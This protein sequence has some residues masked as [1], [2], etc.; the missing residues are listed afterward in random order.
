MGVTAGEQERA[1][2]EIIYCVEC[3]LRPA[4]TRLATAIRDEFGLAA[5]LEEGHGGIF[6]VRINDAVVFNNF[7]RGGRL[8]TDQQIFQEIREHADA[9]TPAQG[10][11]IV[12]LNPRGYPPAIERV[13]LAPRPNTLDGK[14]VYLV[15]ARFDDSDRLLQQMQHWFAEHMPRTRTVL[16]SKDGVYTY[17][18]AA[19]FQQIKENGDAMI[20]GVGH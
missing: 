8:P 9:A 7:K 5:T 15:D 1:Q 18:D 11:K 14:T 12:V 10:E 19:L 17:D 2:I 16:V 4:A 6:E 20:M 3:G 13:H